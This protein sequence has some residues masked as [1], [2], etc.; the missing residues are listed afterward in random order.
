MPKEARSR[1]LPLFTEEEVEERRHILLA[2]IEQFNQGFFFQAHETWEDL[3][4]Q[5][6]W[7]VRQFLQGLIQIAAGLV[8]FVRHEYPG[9]VRLMGFGLEK[10]EAFPEGYMRIDTVRLVAEVR[11]ALEGLSGLGPERFEEWDRASAPRI[12]LGD[13]AAAVNEP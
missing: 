12:H 9:T 11:R 8:H 5:S 2:G 1:N 10:I 4:L 3:W 6:P 7:P 13:E